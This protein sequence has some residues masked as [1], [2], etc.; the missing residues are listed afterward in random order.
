MRAPRP[1]SSPQARPR[2][3]GPGVL[4]RRFVRP[5]PAQAPSPAASEEGGTPGG[6]QE[7]ESRQRLRKG[8]RLIIGFICLQIACQLALLVEA[9]SPV[10]VLVRTLAFG[11]S[12]ALLAFVPGRRLRHPAMPYLIAAMIVTALNMLHPQ[13]SS[14][15]AGAAQLGIQLSIL[16]PLFWVTR[17]RVDAA[18][19]RR[20]MAALFLFNAASAGVG[21]LQV[22]FPGSFQPALSSIV[23]N[24]GEAYTRSLQFETAAGERVFRPF[25]LTD[26]P[27]GAATGA[28]YAVLLGAGFLISSRRGL[29]KLLSVGGILVGCVS[30]YLCQVRAIAVMLVVCLLAIA[31][32]LLL[33]GRLLRLVWLMAVVGGLTVVGVG[34]AVT[35]GGEATMARWNSLFARDAGEVYYSNRGYFLEGTL[36]YFLPEYPLGAGLG[37]YGMANAYFGDN[38]D[39]S[40]PPLWTEI[41]WTAWVLDGGV[42]VMVLYP[43]AVVLTTL[44]ALRLAL[45]RREQGEFWLWGCIIFAYD[46]GALS[47]TFSYPFFMGQAG[48]E[49]WL[50][51]AALF[52]AFAHAAGQAPRPAPHENLHAH[53]R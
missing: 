30:L 46:L 50:L 45:S 53:R 7:A 14:V 19:F 48:M 17:L 27:G 16:A 28:F 39:P 25:G 24:L 21:V 41:Q 47:L 9:I 2:L 26:T 33:S 15:L 51:N 4:R 12:L 5:A 13:T 38:S 35:F 36:E 11:L 18:A 3:Q 49:F 43:L 40:R 22:L 42:L 32:V 23:E 6:E 29:V 52:G 8:G 44:W 10:R 37:R 1:G 20:T 31:L 34:W